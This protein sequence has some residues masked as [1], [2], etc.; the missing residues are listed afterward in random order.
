LK[1]RCFSSVGKA[2]ILEQEGTVDIITAASAA[3]LRTFADGKYDKGGN[4]LA[5]L[6]SV[7]LMLSRRPKVRQF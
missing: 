4:E 1:K 2:V 6:R 5:L 7:R 3:G